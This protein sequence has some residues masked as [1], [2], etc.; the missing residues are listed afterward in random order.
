[1]AEDAADAVEVAPGARYCADS[2]SQD[3]AADGDE[4]R[5]RAGV[6]DRRPAEARGQEGAGETG[7]DAAEAE[8]QLE[9]PDG[10]DVGGTLRRPF[11]D[12]GNG[13]RR[14]HAQ[15]G[16]QA[17]AETGELQRAA[18]DRPPA[19]AGE[20]HAIQS[21]QHHLAPSQPVGQQALQHRADRQAHDPARQHHADLR[22]QR[23]PGFQDQ[24]NRIGRIEKFVAVEKHDD[25]DERP[26]LPVKT[27]DLSAFDFFAHV[28]ACCH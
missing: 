28:E 16:A 8:A 19:Q 7:H 17:Q 10:V 2:G 18:G 22:G 20:A 15:G 26:Q 27:A 21:P 4:H 14:D 12:I 23:M 24:R 6:I 3:C 9:H 25:A 1:L 13:Q 11:I 5:G